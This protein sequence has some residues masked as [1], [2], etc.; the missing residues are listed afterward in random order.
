MR[1]GAL[2]AAGFVFKWV[3]IVVVMGARPK[4]LESDLPK[5][6]KPKVVDF[7]RT[8]VHRES[9]TKQ[10]VGPSSADSVAL[11]LQ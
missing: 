8:L 3:V 10:Y 4:K 2:L 9:S 6:Q 1:V 11:Q 7:L 5:R